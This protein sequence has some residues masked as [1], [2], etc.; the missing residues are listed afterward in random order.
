M[1][2]STTIAYNNIPIH[3]GVQLT[4]VLKLYVSLGLKLSA[5]W[6]QFCLQITSYLV[7][8]DINLLM[9]SS[10]PIQTNYLSKDAGLTTERVLNHE[11]RR[12]SKV[13]L[14]FSRSALLDVAVIRC[15]YL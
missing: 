10:K 13:S 2:S 3:Q 8:N 6:L 11:R 15:F 4:V 7:L 9:G 14:G 5:K 1:L 12:S